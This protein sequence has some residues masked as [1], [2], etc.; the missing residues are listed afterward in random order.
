M[1]EFNWPLS[2]DNDKM[3]RIRIQDKYKGLV[4]E[5]FAVMKQLKQLQRKP[6]KNYEASRR[7]EPMTSPV[8]V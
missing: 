8:L 1:N 3:I 7:F 5:I 2:K 4:K 6:R